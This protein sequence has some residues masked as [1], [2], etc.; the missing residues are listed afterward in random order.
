MRSSHHSDM[1][2]SVRI[3]LLY[4]FEE[5]LPLLTELQKH[6]K[7]Q[8]IELSFFNTRTFKFS[9]NKKTF[10]IL[11]LL[12]KIPKL[13]VIIYKAFR[14]KKILALSQKYQ[15]IDIHFFS[16]IYDSVLPHLKDNNV[17]ISFWG[18]DAYRI[19][20]SR[21]Q[22]LDNLTKFASIIRFNTQEMYFKMKDFFSEQ[23]KLG[24][25]IFGNTYI[26]E[27]NRLEISSREAKMKL[28]LNQKKITLCIGY[29]ASKGQQHCKI[30]TELNDL[31]NEEKS[32]LELVVPLTYGSDINAKKEIIDQAK[33]TGIEV[34]FFEKQMNFEEIVYLRKAS[35]IH[36][37]MQVSDAFSASIQEHFSAGS[38]MVL[39]NWLPYEWLREK[40]MYFH[41]VDF[42]EIKEKI[43]Q[44]IQ[45]I[46]SEKEKFLK[47]NDILFSISSWNSVVHSWSEDYKKL[48]A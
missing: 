44:I 15:G 32:M 1:N 6:L 48:I 26:E 35:D 29:N 4:Q 40:G 20:S 8:N 37:N 43:S 34:M 38:I 16:S 21:L 41:S 30:F 7:A 2:S 5:H 13:R 12:V 22:S 3:L 46:H 28:G 25:Q 31:K 11:Q 18:S 36:L 9:E 23:D 47:N 14:K 39:G 19:S 27:M 45:E 24:F 17:K 10:Y 33:K 42:F